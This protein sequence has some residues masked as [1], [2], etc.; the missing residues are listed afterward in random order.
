MWRVQIILC[1]V[2]RC[3]TLLHCGEKGAVTVDKTNFCNGSIS[4]HNGVREIIYRKL[5]NI[6][7]ESVLINI[8][9]DF[10]KENIS[11]RNIISSKCVKVIMKQNCIFS[12]LH[13]ISND[14]L[15]RFRSTLI[16]SDISFRTLSQC[17]M[18]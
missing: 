9:M 8:S 4:V 3:G 12:T 13:V 5:D 17:D 7:S 10:C 18:K 1:R 6:V 15:S 14:L 2:H 16:Y 11:I